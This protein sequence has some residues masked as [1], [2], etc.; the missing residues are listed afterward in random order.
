MKR[1]NNGYAAWG[2]VLLL[3]MPA[4][5]QAETL[6]ERLRAQ[7]RSTTQQLQQVQ[8]QQAQLSAGK[9]AAEAERDTA[10]NELKTLRGELSA[11]RKKAGQLESEQE[12]VRA[13]AA[14][15]IASSR[16]QAAKAQ[17]AFQQLER[18]A[19]AL[20]SDA[21]AL[22]GHLG[23]R[24]GQLRQCVMKNEEMYRA[25]R[26]LLSAYEAFG[27]GELIAVRQPFSGKARVLFDERAQA[28]GDRLYQSQVAASVAPEPNTAGQQ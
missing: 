17:S 22:K 4:L 24:D 25:G 15:Q 26:E 23:E 7:L 10:R 3:A 5:S 19:T 8:S 16:E 28:F 11:L 1:L 2:V 18:Q 21:T 12:A 20:Q 13:G 9:S 6:E 27:S 14:E